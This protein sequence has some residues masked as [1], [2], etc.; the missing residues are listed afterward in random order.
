LSGVTV[1]GRERAYVNEVLSE[2][3]SLA[4]T[5]YTRLC[6]QWL[7]A[8]LRAR[9]ALL[10][11]SGT[12]ALEMAAL[13]LDIGPGDEVIMPS[14]TFASTAN[15]FVLRGAVPVFVDIHPETLNIDDRRVAA[16]ITPKTRAIVV[17]HYGGDACRMDAIRAVAWQHG[18]EVIED[19]AH[20]L[21]SDYR[22]QSLGTIG[23]LGVLSFHATK[24]V[25]CGQGGALLINEPRDLERAEVLRD[26]GT[27]R[28]RF[29]RGDAPKYSWE[30]IGSSY[31]V[32]ELASAFL[33]GQLEQ[34]PALTARRRFICAAYRERLA[35][36]QAD[37]RLRLPVPQPN[38]AGNGHIFHVL[39][40]DRGARDRLLAHLH[41]NGIDAAFHYVPLHSAPAGLRF[42]RCAEA[43]FVTEQVAETIV[44]LPVFPELTDAHIDHVC[45]AV[46][47][48][49]LQDGGPDV[50]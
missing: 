14:F 44:R 50:I 11:P 41:K 4:G 42:G 19:A 13:L 8:T 46:R 30:D 21:L 48:F 24:N 12:A 2:P 40:Q 10:V 17:V 25:T 38:Q 27:G 33:Y 7:E 34:A 22:G 15:A 45:D 6:E 39:A 35:P 20:A 18:I 9:R 16:A 3:S 29:L 28:A 1:A 47:S 37:G 31:L 23:R 5:R 26:A 49:Y 43:L 32:S 36:L